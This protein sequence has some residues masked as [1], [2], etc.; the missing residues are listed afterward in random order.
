MP[1]LDRLPSELGGGLGGDGGADLR[2]DGGADSLQRAAILLVVGAVV[3]DGVPEEE[4]LEHWSFTFM[5]R[6]HS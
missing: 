5:R 1:G 6:L 4:R 2:R 3:L